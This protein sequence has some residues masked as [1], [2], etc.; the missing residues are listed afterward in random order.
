MYINISVEDVIE[1]VRRLK[2]G[3]SDGEEDL[4]SDLTIHG[5]RIRYVQLTLVIN[6]M[7][8]H[9]Y[10][11]DSMLVGTMIPIPKDNVS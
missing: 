1:G 10:I 5:P 4:N 9:G 7:L 2:L 8:V 3:K 11:P 6:S